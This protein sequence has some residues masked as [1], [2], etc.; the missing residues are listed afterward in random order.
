MSKIYYIEMSCI[1][2]NKHVLKFKRRLFIPLEEMGFSNESIPGN[3]HFSAACET[4]HK[5]RIEIKQ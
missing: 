3:F 2:Q 4:F 1:Y 5:K